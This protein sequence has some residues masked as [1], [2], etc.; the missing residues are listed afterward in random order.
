MRP[1]GVIAE[2]ADAG[3]LTIE[4]K[5]NL[6]EPAAADSAETRKR[7]L[8]ATRVQCVR[9]AQRDPRK[10]EVG[11]CAGHPGGPAAPHPRPANLTSSAPRNQLATALPRRH[12]LQRDVA[13]S[14]SA[15][16]EV[17]TDTVSVALALPSAAVPPHTPL[18]C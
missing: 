11:L 9:E 1:R 14:V 15:V 5:V 2:P 12:Q 16:G 6:L 18:H 13:R 10:L 3:V 8:R 17:N 7:F 4:F